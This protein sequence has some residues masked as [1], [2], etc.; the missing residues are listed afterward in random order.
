MLASD[1]IDLI[2]RDRAGR[3]QAMT[4]M[5][6]H[7][8][9]KANT[10]KYV[11]GKG[12]TREEAETIFCD[13]IVNFVKNC[14][15]ADFEV[16]SSLENYLFGVTRNLWYRTL[17][18]RKQLDNIED[19][20][21]KL[22]QETPE[23]LLMTAEKRQYLHQLLLRLDEK[24]RQVLQYWATDMKMAAIAEEMKYSSAEVVRK[25]K[26]FCLKKL[27]SLVNDHP[28]I[29]EALKSTK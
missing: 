4:H 29:R 23:L 20:K 11:L 8:D 18:Q 17:R 1:L 6:G 13:A 2:R 19:Q 25:K 10:F 14:Y 16:K 12:G 26:H 7:K 15:K 28:E 21:E 22:D 24:C 9:L 5:Y 27:I 3:D